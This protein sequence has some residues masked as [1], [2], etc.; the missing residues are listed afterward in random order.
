MSASSSSP[1]AGVPPQA[2]KLVPIAPGSSA[3]IRGPIS[4]AILSIVTLGIYL[5]FWW[6]FVNREMADYGR[7]RGTKELGDSPTK[8]LL[9]LFPGALIVV[10]VIWTTVT[11]FQRIQSAQRLNG[12]TAVN[13]WLGFVL[14]L[15]FSPALYGYMQSGL[16][17][18][19]RA[20]IPAN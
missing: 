3:K 12:Q 1:A 8:S 16:N 19:W 6:Y 11:T 13:G 4:V 15:V 9:A 10:P 18:A 17:S 5:L 14:Y 20:T 7:S 2:E